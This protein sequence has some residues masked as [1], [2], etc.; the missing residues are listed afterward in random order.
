MG[1]AAPGD[2]GGAPR[3]LAQPSS[4]RRSAAPATASTPWRRRCG[5]SAGRSDFADAVLRAANLGD[6]ADTT[7]AIAGQL[8]GARWGVA[9]I[10][11]TMARAGRRWRR[12]SPSWPPGCS[13]PGGGEPSRRTWPHDDFVHA[14]WVEPGR[15]LAG[16]YPGAPRPGAWPRRR[17]TCSSTPGSARSSISRRRPTDSNRTRRSSPR[18]RPARRLDSATATSGSPTSASATTRP[19]T[20]SST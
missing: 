16:E 20:S 19:T 7:A 18:R 13:A 3:Q 10:P 2:R 4:R 8:A 5:R 15:I 6:D 9:G 11:P 17:S 12:G 1:R 14:W